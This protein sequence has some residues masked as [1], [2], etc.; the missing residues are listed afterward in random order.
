[1]PRAVQPIAATV[2]V[3]N[4]LPPPALLSP[5]KSGGKLLLPNHPRATHRA[6]GV[7]GPRVGD[8]PAAHPGAYAAQRPAW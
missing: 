1:M 3:P 8:A 4:V 6:G 7:A 5:I 2:S